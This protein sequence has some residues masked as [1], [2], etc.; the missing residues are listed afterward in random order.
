[1][2][3]QR[4]ADGKAP[5]QFEDLGLRQCD[6]FWKDLPHANI[7]KCFTP[8]L[9]HQLHKGMFKDHV[10]SWATSSIDGTKKE[11][12]AELDERF[13]VMPDHPHLR[14]FKRGISLV[15]QWTGNEYKHM[16]RVF[17]GALNGTA[18]TR[19]VLAVRGILDFIHYAH[20]ETHTDE[21]LALLHEAWLLFHANKDVF[22]DLEIRTDFDGIPKLHKMIH[23][24]SSIR[25]LG[26]TSGYNTEIPERLHIDYAKLPYRAS[27]HQNYTSQMASWLRRRESLANFEL[28]LKWVTE[29]ELSVEDEDEDDEA[30]DEA[31]ADPVEPDTDDAPAPSA[32]DARYTI[33]KRAPFPSVSVHSLET[34]FGANDFLYHLHDFLAA[35]LMVPKNF[36][37]ISATFSVYKRVRIKIP[38]VV[39]VSLHDIDD[40]VRATRPIEARALKHRVPAH[41]DTI[42]GYLKETDR[43]TKRLRLV[44]GRIRAIFALPIEYGEYSVPLAYIEWFRPLNSFDKTLAMFK[45]TPAFRQHAR[46]ASIIPITQINRSCHLIPKFPPKVDRTLT[47][48]DVL[49][50][51]TEFYLNPYL[52]HI[53]FVLLRGVRK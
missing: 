38:T 5:K 41:F 4:N 43:P 44:P 46:H 21:S 15:S 36:N 50:R 22:I 27:N 20:F 12:E 3:M 47:A 48:D 45:V 16:E 8:D 6:P 2:I 39:Q 33:A 51:V 34:D 18:E 37:D 19:V 24:I 10:V 26:V 49:E 9:L 23:Y 13:K 29:A 7:F 17:L 25:A 53:D 14:H 28:Y 52:R 31:A 32:V 42:L 1:D 40:V 11:S 35:N 30:T